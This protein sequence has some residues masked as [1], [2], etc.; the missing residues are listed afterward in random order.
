MRITFKAGLQNIYICNFRN[1]MF[2]CAILEDSVKL[3]SDG[4]GGVITVWTEFSAY[5]FAIHEVC[6]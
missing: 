1:L 4:S 2:Y 6:M 3:T 5:F